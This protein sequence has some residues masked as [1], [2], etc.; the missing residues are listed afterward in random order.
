MEQPKKDKKKSVTGDYIGSS[1]NELNYSKEDAK[2]NIIVKER[3]TKPIGRESM[4][5]IG[6]KLDASGQA[7]PMAYEKKIIK[8]KVGSGQK[9]REFD[10]SGKVI[11]EAVPGSD[12][13]KELERKHKNLKDYTAERRGKQADVHNYQTGDTEGNPVYDKK[14]ADQLQADLNRR[15][16]I[17]V[18]KGK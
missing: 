18:K 5:R 2:R 13:E 16:M 3:S 10:S 12:K 14:F 1:A 4:G 7:T 17:K 11:S 9:T 6:V 15:K 8:A